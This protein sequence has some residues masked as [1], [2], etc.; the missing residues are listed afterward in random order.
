[1]LTIKK[2][3]PSIQSAPDS[4][5]DRKVLRLAFLAPELQRDILSGRQ[6]LSLSLEKLKH[7]YIPLCWKAQREALGWH[8]APSR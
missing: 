1:M 5:Y 4:P 8:T 2:G 6:P 3:M 7:L